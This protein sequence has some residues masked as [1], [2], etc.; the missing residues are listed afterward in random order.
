MGLFF[1]SFNRRWSLY[2]VRGNQSAYAMHGNCVIQIVGYVMGYFA[3]DRKPIPPWNLYLCSNGKQIQLGPEYFTSDGESPTPLL[4]QQIESIDS[5]WNG[6]KAGE[7]WC[8]DTVTKKPLKISE[9]TP[10]KI[11][12]QAMFDNIDK[13]RELTFFAVMDEVFEKR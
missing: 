12:V 7:I 2:V 1:K 4:I 8:E 3:N 13:P 10:G 9:Y 11:D 5:R 6:F